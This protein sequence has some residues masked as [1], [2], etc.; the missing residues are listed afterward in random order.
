M[1]F[2]K[3]GNGR[4]TT[5]QD[6]RGEKMSLAENFDDDDFRSEITG[7]IYRHPK[8]AK[9]IALKVGASPRTVENWRDGI[10]LP[11]LPHFF[12][13]AMEIPELRKLALRWL[14]ADNGNGD[15]PE[16]LADEIAKFLMERQSK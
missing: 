3:N 16:K 10:S 7:A 9:V 8:S 2:S 5:P 6:L 4:G 1:S 14:D 15:D 13:L 12:A 11:Q